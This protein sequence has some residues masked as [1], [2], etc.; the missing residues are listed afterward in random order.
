MQTGAIQDLSLPAVA[1]EYGVALSEVVDVVE[2]RAGL[3]VVG[4]RIVRAGIASAH[5][6]VNRRSLNR[7]Y[8]AGWSDRRAPRDPIALHVLPAGAG[9][10]PG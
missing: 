6:P 8:A 4:G 2:C 3:A 5:E 1:R 7:E 10:A 9:R